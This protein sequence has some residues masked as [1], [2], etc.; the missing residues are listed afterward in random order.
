MLWQSRLVG[1]LYCTTLPYLEA[2]LA[3]LLTTRVVRPFLSLF[4]FFGRG[5]GQSE[6][7]WGVCI[8]SLAPPLFLVRMSALA[9][10]DTVEGWS[11]ATPVTETTTRQ[12]SAGGESGSWN[13]SRR[14]QP[15]RCLAQPA[16]LAKAAHVTRRLIGSLH[17]CHPTGCACSFQG[18]I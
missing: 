17:V 13:P 6:A 5:E 4:F 2:K 16:R 7:K 3:R 14:M 15:E 9:G 12:A 10:N 1:Y 11:Y 18:N 8:I